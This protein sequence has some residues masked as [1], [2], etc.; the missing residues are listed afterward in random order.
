MSD[1]YARQ[2]KTLYCATNQ[3]L[4]HDILVTSRLIQNQ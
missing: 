3:S 1:N 4:P 2:I